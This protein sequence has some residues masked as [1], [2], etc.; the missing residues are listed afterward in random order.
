MNRKERK[1]REIQ[2]NIVKSMEIRG[3]YKYEQKRKGTYTKAILHN[4]A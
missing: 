1:K 3:I 4:T 2:H